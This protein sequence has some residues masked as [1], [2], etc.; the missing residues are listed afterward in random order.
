MIVRAFLVMFIALLCL[1]HPVSVA[2]AR[3]SMVE[4]D[5]IVLDPEFAPLVE[6]LRNQLGIPLWLPQEA[7]RAPVAGMRC[8]HYGLTTHQPDSQE[9]PAGYIVR[10]SCWGESVAPNAPEL[11][12]PGAT[13]MVSYLGEMRAIMAPLRPSPRV[14]QM[15]H[16]SSEPTVTDRQLSDGLTAQL[17]QHSSPGSDGAAWQSGA[18]KYYVV[19]DSTDVQSSIDELAPLSEAGSPIP[20]VDTGIVLLYQ[21]NHSYTT[22][23]WQ[24]DGA[25]YELT[26]YDNP[27]AAFAMARSL[28]L[29][30]GP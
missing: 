19:T 21:G 13:A 29:V 25:S 27:G 15:L 16:G 28:V 8:N 3:E 11:L 2:A 20:G 24:A 7:P 23:S 17:F 5:H 22:I 14:D 9:S 26:W 10:M 6:S 1:H 4:A 18:W 30:P 12:R